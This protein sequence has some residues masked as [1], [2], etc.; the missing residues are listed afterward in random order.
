MILLIVIGV[1]V[2]LVV[3]YLTHRTLRKHVENK[4]ALR[5]NEQEQ[6]ISDIQQ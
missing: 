1:V 5:I 6:T 3:V 2:V 4:G